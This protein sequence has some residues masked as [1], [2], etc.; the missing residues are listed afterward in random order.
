MR[1]VLLYFLIVIEAAFAKK[2]FQTNKSPTLA[3][4]LSTNGLEFLSSIGHRI[5]N[6]EF[7]KAEF[8]DIS[9][10]IDDGPGAGTVN[11]T[12]LY[13]PKFESPHFHFKLSPPDGIHFRSRDGAVKVS[14]EW[15]AVYEWGITFYSSGWVEVTASDIRSELT[16]GAFGKRDH[17]QVRIFNCSAEISQLE[18]QIGGGVI[19]WLVNLFRGSVSLAVKKAIHDQ[20]CV[21]TRT[22]ILDELNDALLSLPTHLPVASNIYMDYAY[23][24]QPIVTSTYIQDLIY[25]DVVFAQNTSCSLQPT[26]FQIVS[27]PPD[28]F[29]LNVWV[30]ETVFDCL[31]ESI[32]NANLV[33]FALDKNFAERKFATFLSTSCRWYEICLGKF[34]PTLAKDHPHAHVDLLF[35][36]ARPAT[37]KITSTGMEAKAHFFVDFYLSPWKQHSSNVLARL[38]MDSNSTVEPAIFG[39]RL[40]GQL[41]DTNVSFTEIFS[42]F[43]NFSARFLNTLGVLVKP[44][45]QV[46]V[47]TSLKIGIPIPLVENIHVA[48]RTHLTTLLGV[49]RLDTDLEYVNSTEIVSRPTIIYDGRVIDAY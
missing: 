29:M 30:G 12:N 32:H 43:G 3:A 37:V 13:I 17:P 20:F 2:L 19:P 16:L 45:M 27:P 14:G 42:T 44:V 23:T 26:Q 47:D 6:R 25:M 34:F 15:K 35:H 48:N 1:T 33:E 7:P 21:T 38:A 11:V 46:A 40:G 4:R 8:P 36:S 22:A 39:D 24:T 5:V 18:V 28:D 49:I 9:L 41:M 31:L 10:P